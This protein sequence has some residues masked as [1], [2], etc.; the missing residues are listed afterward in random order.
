MVLL[1]ATFLSASSQTVTLA[2]CAAENQVREVIKRLSRRM[3]AGNGEFNFCI[4]SAES[5]ICSAFALLT[6]DSTRLAP[7]IGIITG[8]RASSH[9]SATSKEVA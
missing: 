7:G 8:D 3:N 6:A 2:R 4:S 1:A 9:A 5:L